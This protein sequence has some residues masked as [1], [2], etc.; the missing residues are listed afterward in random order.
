MV[1]QTEDA[2]I[3]L[4]PLRRCIASLNLAGLKTLLK[5]TRALLCSTVRKA[6]RNDVP[7]AFHLQL[8]ISNHAGRGER[9]IDVSWVEKPFCRRPLCVLRPISPHSCQT[10]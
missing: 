2:R 1:R 3:S 9:F 8:V 6:F 7:L 5:P 10:I 4:Q